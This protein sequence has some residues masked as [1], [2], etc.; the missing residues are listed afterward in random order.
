MPAE[1]RERGGVE[2]EKVKCG[3]ISRDIKRFGVFSISLHERGTSRTLE[4]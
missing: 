1:H 4:N 2:R 3:F